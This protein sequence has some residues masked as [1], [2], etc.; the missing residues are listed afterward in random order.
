MKFLKISLILSAVAFFIFA[1]ARTNSTNTNSSNTV[2]V[3]S[4]TT[5]Q[6]TS[7][8]DDLASS[9]KIF[10][11]K[12]AKCHKDDGSGGT[13]DVDGIKIKAPNLTSDRQKN[14]TDKAYLEIIENGAKE[15][16]MPAF[17]GDLS[18]EEIKN[19]VRYVR[20]DFQGK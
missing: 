2:I 6:P 5:T 17:K 7:A 9:K 13:S 12:C 10:T 18:D 4:N 14:K 15:D 16:G 19:L 8:T 1:C 20:R 11:E 3:A